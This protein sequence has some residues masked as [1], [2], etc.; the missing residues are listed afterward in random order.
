[1]GNL[2]LTGFEPFG[3]DEVNPSLEAVMRLDGQIIGGHTVISRVIPTVFGEAAEHLIR[4]V[5][6]FKPLVTISVGQAGGRAEIS[7]ERVAINVDD[8][9]IPDNGGNQPIDTPVVAGGPVGYWSTLPIKAIVSS[10]REHDIPSS[11]SNTAGTFVCNHLF[12][13]LMHE[14]AQQNHESRGGFIHIPFLPKQVISR[15]QQPSMEL[16]TIVRALQIAI[17][18]T[19]DHPTDIVESGGTTH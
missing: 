6:E 13:S 16:N 11:V 17:Q 10:L 3:A 4:Y 15:P 19:L 1:M 9:R 14:L 8:A 2:L 7:I 12:Y 18:A 5:R